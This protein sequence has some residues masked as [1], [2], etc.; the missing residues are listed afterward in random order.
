[1]GLTGMLVLA[2][3]MT[4]LLGAEAAYAGP[5]F[6][7]GYMEKI[8]VVLG[9]LLIFSVVFEVAYSG[10]FSWRRFLARLEGKGW[11]VPL[12]LLGALIFT[13]TFNIDFMRDL[14]VA[15]KYPGYGTETSPTG[16]IITAFLLTGGSSG[17]LEIFT[18]LGIRNPVAMKEKAEEAKR[19][20]AEEA[21][22]QL[23]EAA[24]RKQALA[25][26]EAKRKAEEDAL[27]QLGSSG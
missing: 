26:A 14:M 1:M 18:K 5:G 6:P 16:M 10:L 4:T 19:Q 8:G 24:K 9:N 22:R 13:F 20:L 12:V 21:K 27:K 3:G 2:A 11:K 23:E 15:M 25:E 17:V 7:P